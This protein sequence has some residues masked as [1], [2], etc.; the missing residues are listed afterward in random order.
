MGLYIGNGETA[1]LVALMRSYD[2]AGKVICEARY[3][4]VPESHLAFLGFSNDP[5]GRI[6]AITLDYGDTLLSE[7]I[8]DLYFRPHTPR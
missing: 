5:D 1:Q 4:T 3:S 6:V 7:S 8:D 2:A